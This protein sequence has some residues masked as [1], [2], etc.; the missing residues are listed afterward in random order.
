MTTHPSGYCKHHLTQW[1]GFV[2]PEEAEGG[3]EAL[4]KKEKKKSKARQRA[5]KREAEQRAAME[6]EG[7]FSLAQ[8]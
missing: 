3:D 8:K 7:N 2:A 6:A 1:E 4:P 5:E